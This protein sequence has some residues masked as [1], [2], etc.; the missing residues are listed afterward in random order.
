MRPKSQI[1]FAPPALGLILS[2]LFCGGIVACSTTS[3]TVYVQMFEWPWADIAKEC[4]ER[5]GPLGFAAV[6]VSPRRKVIPR[7]IRPGGTVINQ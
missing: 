7:P 2:A 4:E 3:R 6:Q 5:L 1:K